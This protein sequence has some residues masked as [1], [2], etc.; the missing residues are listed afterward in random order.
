[1]SVETTDSAGDSD[2]RGSPHERPEGT[3]SEP[4]GLDDAFH[5]LQ[6]QR[7]RWV[8]QHLHD[9]D[10]TV[11]MGDLAERVAA[12]EHDTTVERLTSTQRQRVYIALYQ[13]HLPKLDDMDVV[14]Y[15]QSR[16]LVTSCERV[17]RLV[18]YLDGPPVD[19][20]L[21]AAASPPGDDRNP[22]ESSDGPN[23]TANRDGSEDATERIDTGTRWSSYPFAV[24]VFSGAALALT[25][26][27]VSSFA[28]TRLVAGVS[29][30]TT[31]LLLS[32]CWL[33]G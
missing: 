23:E 33:R 13:R 26:L 20:E 27:G 28:T 4:F 8:L 15:N 7:R 2:S 6:N 21:D 19:H 31:F 5:L 1:M 3:E 29:A 11:E 25:S 14:D 17:T 30:V 9:V 12:W 22:E 32:L 18:A 24:S 10:E 16:G